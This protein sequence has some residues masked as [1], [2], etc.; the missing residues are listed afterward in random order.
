MLYE[1][2]RSS[3]VRCGAKYWKRKDR[4]RSPDYC[5]LQCRKAATAERVNA[6]RGVNCKGCGKRFIARVS[7]LRGDRLP[8]C[9]NSCSSSNTP[10]T[11]EWNKNLAAA[12]KASGYRPPSGKDNP[13]WT[14]GI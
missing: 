14:G 4:V 12:F 8:Y 7:Q 1:K 3:C 10:R 9:S 11:E 2:I 13:G 5:N 6:D